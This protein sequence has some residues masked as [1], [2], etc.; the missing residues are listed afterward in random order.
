M[1]KLRRAYLAVLESRA[2]EGD[3]W[4]AVMAKH[5]V[6]QVRFSMYLPD[7]GHA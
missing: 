6:Q 2:T 4:A 7:D 5:G 3:F 1:E